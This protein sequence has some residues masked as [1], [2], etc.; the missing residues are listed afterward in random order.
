MKY[1]IDHDY[2]IHSQLSSCSADPEQT[3]ERLLRYARENGLKRI[4][5]TDH[6]WDS[7][8]EGMSNW[9]KP[10][11]FEHI[12]EAKPLP[13]SDGVE[14][15]FGCETDMK[16]DTVIGIPAERFDDFKF[17]IIP[18]THLHMHGFTISAED[19]PSPEAHARLWVERM[20]ALL[21]MDIPF[22]K[23]GVA[24]LAC[25]LLAK[26]TESGFENNITKARDA[27]LDLIP[28][29]ELERIFAKAAEK[30]IGIE[31]NYYDMKNATEST[32][33]PFR[34]AKA[35]G[36]KFY[37]GSDAHHP[38]D[39]DKYVGVM[40]TAVEKLGLAEDDKFHIDGYK[41]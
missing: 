5:L 12:A 6:Y 25:S 7:A 20:D 38:A 27:V 34:I 26:G 32:L 17:V 16:R 41:D 15:L 35:K 33:R 23:T 14:F 13:K 29:S 11:N 8:V 21:A 9:Y 1:V 2:H 18:T 39:L 37:C 30:G 24:H 40:Q 19:A 22:R 36:C 10:Q 28:E 31:L 3:P 4:V